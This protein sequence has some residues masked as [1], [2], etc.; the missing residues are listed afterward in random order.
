[1]KILSF[2]P[3]G[4]TGWAKY[5]DEVAE[6]V[7]RWTCGQ[8]G[9]YPHHEE[10][11]EFLHKE[12]PDIV[13]CESFEYRNDLPKAELISCEYIGIIKLYAALERIKL[14]VVFQTAGAGK[15]RS[16]LPGRKGSFVQ[17]RHLEKLS[18]WSPGNKHAMDGY[19][20]LLYYVIHGGNPELKELRQRILEVG[21]KPNGTD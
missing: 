2:D 3:G 19:G 9:P 15:V 6:A 7:P 4:T 11:Y 10:L 1:M 16:D 13:V 12:C 18:L 20:H 17:R 5:N 21:W 14:P 8:L